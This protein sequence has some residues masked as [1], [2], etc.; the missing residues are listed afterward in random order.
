VYKLYS[1]IILWMI[2]FCK[3]LFFL[4]QL[5]LSSYTVTMCTILNKFIPVSGSAK[6][7]ILWH[8]CQHCVRLYYK[9]TFIKA[10]ISNPLKLIYWYNTFKTKRTLFVS[11]LTPFCILQ[12]MRQKSGPVWHYIGYQLLRVCNDWYYN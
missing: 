8:L 7:L 2:I 12:I 9:T 5:L 11:I 1:H 10:M 6:L 4:S 3:N